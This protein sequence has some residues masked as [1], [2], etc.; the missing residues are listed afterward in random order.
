M[1]TLSREERD[2]LGEQVTEASCSVAQSW[3]LKTFAYRNPL[4]GLEHFP[5]DQAIRQG[6]HALGGNGY[7]SND[8]YR[9]LYRSGAIGDP[10]V[11][12]A[13]RRFDVTDSD[14]TV[15][16][17][18][19]QIESSD[20]R[21][22]HLLFGF[23]PLDPSLLTWTLRANAATP[24]G[25]DSVTHAELW[26]ST[27][28]A[29]KRVQPSPDAK[30]GAGTDKPVT[31]IDLPMGRTLS[32]WLDVL[33]D[34]GVVDQINDQM[35]KWSAAFLDEGMSSWQMPGRQH[36]FYQA[37]RVLAK[38]D[39]SG[40]FLGIKKFSRKVRELP[41]SA[42]DAIAQ[43]LSRLGIPRSRW[44]EY[45]GRQ[46]A[47]LPGWAG[48]IRW[49]GENHDYPAQRKHPIDASQY[50]AVR[51]FY[52]VELVEATCRREWEIEGTLPSIVSAWQDRPSEYQQQIAG[53]CHSIDEETRL[54]CT[55]GWRL[56]HLAQSMELTP[57]EVTALSDADLRTLLGWID[58]MPSEDHG[59]VWLEAL[60]TSYRDSLIANLLGDTG[61]AADS[62]GEP[63]SAPSASESTTHGQFVFC[64][65]VRS[66]P[67][68]RQIE[69]RGRYQTFGFA[70]FFGIPMRYQ[71][72]DSHDPAALCP[73]ILSPQFDVNEIPRTGQTESLQTYAASS[74][75][76]RLGDHLFHDLKRNVISSFM[77]IDVL[78]VFFSGLLAGK[79]FFGRAYDSLVNRAWDKFSRPIATQIPVVLASPVTEPVVPILPQGFTVA[80]QAT[81]VGNALRAIGLTEGLGRFVVLCGHG[82][83]SE[84]NP[85]FAAYNCGACGGG[86]GDAN[87]RVFAAMANDPEVR[88]AVGEN[89]L[90]IPDDTRFIAAKHNTVTDSI[91]FYDREELPESH[92]EDFRQMRQDV[93]LASTEQAKH[94]VLRLPQAP[95]NLS[96]EEAR[97]HMLARSADWANVRPEWGLSGNAAFILGRR[98]L[99]DGVDLDGRV[100]LQSYDPNVDP[101]GGI[102]EA[103]MTA[104]L[105]VAQWISMEYYFS[106]VDPVR[107]GSGSKVTHNVVSGIGV[108]HGAHGDLQS[109]LPMQSVNDGSKHY[110][111]PVR[112]LALIEAPT[113]RIDA[114]VEKHVLLQ[115]LL[116]NQW[117]NL[118]AVD[119]T[120]GEFRRYNPNSTWESLS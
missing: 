40:R 103:L 14:R 31:E 46:F 39:L 30:P 41:D 72:F 48:F 96:P 20:V 64:I 44:T 61:L 109:G 36:G 101:D 27:L 90:Q 19:R 1:P 17:G 106:A 78:G 68:R 6:K 53:N 50:L 73:V 8:D 83:T 74:R 21:R 119:P 92:A 91:T 63:T 114:A 93:D 111:Q 10:A 89:G 54:V 94:R 47:Q 85:Y 42:E 13:L 77:L 112:L 52:E 38:R 87:A 25:G 57:R 43:S 51:L 88:Q 102:L 24:N 12:Q 55:E 29:V 35:I 60:E 104:P 86:H 66:E 18:A 69:A 116:N 15:K 95:D 23:D 58:A 110:H 70:G 99:T 45:L 2:R 108:M 65:D 11:D 22:L 62:D 67:M 81:F 107:Y 113:S 26:A 37:W 71:A 115:Q 32:D 56:F 76:Q 80:Q 28:D 33:S 5:F 98:A 105:V 84:N 4:R 100:F 16:V 49:R 118:V 120:D 82:S 3:P 7:L 97:E 75:W 34:S 117:I 9:D 79:T 59:P